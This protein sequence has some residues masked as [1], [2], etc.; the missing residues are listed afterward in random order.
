MKHARMYLG[1]EVKLVE[2]FCI[3]LLNLNYNF[4]IKLV[5]FN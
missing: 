4:K 3:K 1:G 2:I 5:L